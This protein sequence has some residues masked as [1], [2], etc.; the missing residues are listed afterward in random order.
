ML[1][2]TEQQSPSA[3]SA[4][5][6][7]SLPTDPGPPAPVEPVDGESP[8]PFPSAAKTITPFSGREI[9]SFIGSVAGMAASRGDEAAAAAF[10]ASYSSNALPGVPLS[11][12]KAAWLDNLGIGE[13]L[14]TWG[15]GRETFANLLGENAADAPWF[16]RLL[17]AAVI[18][19]AGVYGGVRAANDSLASSRAGN[20]SSATPT[21]NRG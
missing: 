11:I 20:T 3:P 9:V 18:V 1:E 2:Q 10:M 7:E 8:E 15:I 13:L 12:D 6:F 5:P 14:A 4:P 21:T 19:G 17:A 16:V